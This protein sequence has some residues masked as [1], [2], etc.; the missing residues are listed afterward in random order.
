M[1]F[2]RRHR[3]FSRETI[4][5]HPF[6]THVTQAYRILIVFD[7]S[8]SIFLEGHAPFSNSLSF[9]LRRLI[10]LCSR[11]SLGIPRRWPCYTSRPCGWNE[12]EHSL[13]SSKQLLREL[14]AFKIDR[15]RVCGSAT[16]AWF[17]ASA[18]DARYDHNDVPS[19]RVAASHRLVHPRVACGQIST[20]KRIIHND[21]TQYFSVN[22]RLNTG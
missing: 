8:L 1:V 9:R 10:S 19:R 16:S 2:R 4:L 7:P 21:S 15:L 13:I 6:L 14:R 20:S 12:S 5:T 22:R 17:R 3:P 11:S 18:S